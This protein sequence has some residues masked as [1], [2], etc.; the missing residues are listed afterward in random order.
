MEYWEIWNEPDQDPDDSPNKR[1]WGGTK[2]QFFDFY[3]IVAKHLKGRFPNF[4]LYLL[5]EEHTN[6]YIK[7]V[8]AD[9]ELTLQRNSIVLLKQK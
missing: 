4:E 5:D 8:S 1:T 7:D 9:F 6:E 2:A 3:E